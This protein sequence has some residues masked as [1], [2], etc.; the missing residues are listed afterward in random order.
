MEVNATPR[1]T[2][3]K[4]AARRL[5]HAGKVPGVLYGA[6]KGAEQIELEH[7]ELALNLKH[8]AFHASILTL[9]LAGEKQ[10]VLLRDIQMHPW[11]AQVMH[12]DFQRVAKDK[13]V[14]IK[15][16][17]HFVHAEIAPGV[18]TGGGSVNHVMTEIDI[19]CLPGDL[20]EFIEVDLAHLEMGHSIHLSELTLPKGVESVQLR[21]GDDAVVATIPVPRAEV[22][23][24]AEAA[25]AAAPVEGAAAVP[26]AVPAP[27]QKAPEK[28]EKERKSERVDRR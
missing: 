5:R 1:G 25:A 12:V 6:D 8:E 24:E 9:N 14:R 26:G 23:A 13:K 7:Q 20:P 22:E 28:E 16:P 17:L 10:Q 19:T 27:E 15:V 4:G 11:R 3:G 21:S 18:K 2:Q